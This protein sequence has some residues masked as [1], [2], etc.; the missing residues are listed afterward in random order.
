M[1]KHI[2]Y[3][4]VCTIFLVLWLPF[5]AHSQQDNKLSIQVHDNTFQPI[6]QEKHDYDLFLKWG[7]A[8]FAVIALILLWNRRL[9]REIKIRIKAEVELEKNRET[10]KTFN[11]EL[12]KRIKK[13]TRE[14]ELSNEELSREINERKQAEA[15]IASQEDRM[16]AILDHSPGLISIKDL[17]GKYVMVNRNYRNIKGAEH[18]DDFIGK[19]AYDVFP[20]STADNSWK[21][22]LRTLENKS[23][24]E[25]EETFVHKDGSLHTYLTVK[26]PLFDSKEVPFGVCSIATDITERV[27]MEEE[28]RQTEKMRV[29][30]QLAGGVA[31]DFN[32]QLAGILGFS[33]ILQ[34]KIK[35]PHLLKSI[36]N[37]IIASKHASELTQQLL[38]FSRKGKVVTTFL[39]VHQVVEEVRHLL[40]RSI[41]KRIVVKCELSAD[42]DIVLADQSQ[43]QNAILNMGLNASQAMHDGGELVFQSRNISVTPNSRDS[44]PDSLLINDY[45]VLEIR[46]TGH[47]IQPKHMKRIFEPFFTTKDFG[48]GMGLA[49][50][51]GI[52]KDHGGDIEVDSR[53]NEGTVFKIYLPLTE[54][55]PPMIIDKKQAQ[56]LENQKAK[57]MIIDDEEVVRDFLDDFLRMNNY[58]TVI[59]K[60]GKEAVTKYE[61]VFSEIDLII[62][63]M[64]MPDINGREC[65]EQLKKINPNLNVI[66][67]S[68]YCLQDIIEQFVNDGEVTI[69]SK[70]VQ[71][72]ELLETVNSKL[73]TSSVLT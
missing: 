50:V 24:V 63:D 70:P 44:F 20:Y 64:V 14:L 31:H 18:D 6:E 68:G 46:D 43:I 72:D 3:K 69:I 8:I 59:C 22:D 54:K 4:A 25:S 30:G 66:I 23:P 2:I 40:Q 1:F 13:R 45:I 60:S 58:D 53:L 34:R 12:E 32:N 57:I 28:I 49:A 67:L 16:Q 55:Q 37:I 5:A 33:E 61:N 35:D 15:V 19:T 71:F 27:R 52:I 29:I 10:L 36:E 39:P 47:G 73:H 65:Y 62:L 42:N 56:I 48:S 11:K 21:N 41:D 51:Y 26:F 7:S 9:S 17:D 38:A